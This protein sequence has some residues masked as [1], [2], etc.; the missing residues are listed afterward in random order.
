MNGA[1]A[2]RSQ[3]L[4]TY[5][6]GGLFPSESTSFMIAGLHEWDPK[7]AEHIAEPR[8]ARALGV[9]E[10]KAPP[11]GGKRDVP[12]IRYPYTQVC[13]KCRRIGSLRDLSKDPNEARCKEDN[14]DLTPFRLMSA[15]RNGHVS[16]FPVFSWLHKGQYD[17][18]SGDEH[19]MELNVLGRTS[20]LAD[21][22]L[23]CSCGV[24]SRS[25]DG[26]I[27]A[28]SL[29]D[30]GKCK[31]LRPWL[32]PDTN[33]ECDEYPRAV[34]R[35]ASNVWF[36]AVRSSI[37]IPPYSIA[38]AKFVDKHWEMVKDPAAVIPPVLAGLAAMSK[39]RF[40]VDQITREIE[41][42]R[43]E[44]EGD[45][46]ISEAKLRADEYKALVEGREEES[47]DSDFVCLRR[48]VP[49]GF[50]SLISDVR[51]VTRLREVR[52]LQGFTRLD[53]APD[54]SGPAQKLCA[55]SPKH[56]HWLPAIEVI[57]EGVFLAFRRDALEEW[58]GGEFAQ[59]RRRIL[60]KAADRAAADYG[61]PPAPVDIIKVAIHTLSHIIIDQLSLDAGY[62]AS[63]L[64]ER[65][66]VNDKVAG[67]LIYTASSDSA[68][69]L[70]GVASMAE[71][72]HLGAALREGLQR[73]SWCS[74]D[75]VCIESAGSG[76]D[77]LNL[78]AC[79]ACVL[80]PET[81]CEMNNSYLDRA[82]LFGTHDEGCEDAG[83]FC[84]LVEKA[85]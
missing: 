3:L 43:G 50:E 41:R 69:S 5:G 64:R 21:L 84:E 68:G 48:D 10:L 33:E 23:E 53:G 34:Q 51:K 74:S 29:I 58:A 59:R 19:R 37:S 31:G 46:E 35:G 6:V 71:T 49:D 25:L 82:L 8:L 17:K 75:P 77:G 26:A 32:G 20:S 14:I 70:G 54:P 2:R 62:P 11:A 55:L 30:F 67:L 15:C 16:E 76:A 1:K 45:E 9:A 28:G 85:L 13:P 18:S 63:A 83:L 78:A 24:Q 40:S 47:L 39:G 4:S 36:P 81:S 65:L 72:E 12:V 79:H 66:F 52:A 61:R 60:Q 38:I 80:A 27:G 44:A 42:R 73:L 56:E 7:R 22:V 57:G